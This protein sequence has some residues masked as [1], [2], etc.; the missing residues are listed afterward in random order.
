MGKIRVGS[1]NLFNLVLPQTPF[2][3]NRQY[4]Q[5]EYQKK[6]E[7][8][9]HQ[10]R[11]MK[12]DIIGF[13]E[14]F[15]KKALQDCLHKTEGYQKA[16]LIVLGETGEAPV[17][18]LL[19]KFPVISQKSFENFPSSVQLDIEGVPIPVKKFSRPV[20]RVEIDI[21][22]HKLTVFV[23]HLK[24][25]RPLLPEDA[26]DQDPY[27][28]ALGQ[29]RSLTVRAAEAAALR[30]LI[31]EDIKGNSNPVIVIGD[32]NDIGTAVTSRI[33]SGD[34]P[35]RSMPHRRK[36]E[37]WDILLYHTQDI[38]NR[39][40]YRD[41][42]Y[43]YIHNGFYESLDHILVSQEFFRGN[44]RN[45][46][47]VEYVAVLNDHLI[48]TTLSDDRVPPWQSD[49]GQVIVTIRIPEEEQEDDS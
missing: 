11:C 29:A 32:L 22:S 28:R 48:D 2:Y 17:V 46:G 27:Q 20:L 36:K 3:G 19:S 16:S 37:I 47:Y 30:H 7:W 35:P 15:H 10:L 41:V 9:S 34:P 24:S 39:Q 4:T 33:L 5:E 1:F 45:I 42:Y 49:H 12:A 44:S 23:C 26:D 38:Q 21:F 18:G 40:S 31:L 43:T 14:I 13:Q 8:I 6:L 25:K